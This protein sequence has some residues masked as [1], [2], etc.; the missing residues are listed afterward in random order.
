MKRLPGKGRA[1]A[2]HR[3]AAALGVLSVDGTAGHDHH[4]RPKWQSA[5]RPTGRNC[6]EALM[7]TNPTNKGHGLGLPIV[8]KIRRG[9]RGHAGIAGCGGPLPKVPIAGAWRGITLPILPKRRNT[10]ERHIG[11]RPTKRDIRELICDILAGRRLQRRGWPAPPDDCMAEL[12]QGAARADDP[13]HSGLKGYRTWTG[14]DHFFGHVKAANNPR[15]FPLVIHIGAMATIEIAVAAIK[16]GAYDFPFEKN[17]SKHRAVAGG[18]PPW[19]METPSRCGGEKTPNA[20]AQTGSE[21]R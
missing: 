7:S 16:Q 1:A 12:K 11:R 5:F 17:P 19:R 8:K 2:G 14:S 6:F 21:P 15:R 13:R 10:H 18:D 4:F 9:T 20:A 3:P